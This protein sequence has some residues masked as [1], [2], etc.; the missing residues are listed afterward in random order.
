VYWWS[1]STVSAAGG[2]ANRR[3]TPQNKPALGQIQQWYSRSDYKKPA[4]KEGQCAPLAMNA[5]SDNLLY[6]SSPASRKGM[7]FKTLRAGLRY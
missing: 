2:P 6:S 4:V 5:N 3:F 1:W 7:D